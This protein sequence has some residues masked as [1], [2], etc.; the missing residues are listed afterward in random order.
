MLWLDQDLKIFHEISIFQTIQKMQKWQRLQTQINLINYFNRN[1][2]NSA[3][4]DSQCID[5]SMVKHKSLWSMKQYVK[6]EPIKWGFKFWYRC[7]SET[8]YLYQF[9]LYFGKKESADK[10]LGPGAVLKMTKS[11]RYSHSMVFFW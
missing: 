9:D 10:N 5:K 11:L 8:E 6:K 4:S 7:A 3:S 1:F 2:S